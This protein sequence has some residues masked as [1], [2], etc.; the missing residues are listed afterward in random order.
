M[1]RKIY[2]ALILKM[3]N[4][5]YLRSDCQISISFIYQNANE[6]I[7]SCLKVEQPN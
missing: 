5:I 2:F 4:D 7:Q 3:L 6:T 1:R